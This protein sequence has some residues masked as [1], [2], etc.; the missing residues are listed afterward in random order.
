MPTPTARLKAVT[1]RLPLPEE[2][3]R[4]RA[5]LRLTR[6]EGDD[7]IGGGDQAGDLL[8]SRGLAALWRC[9]TRRGSRSLSR[10]A[11]SGYTMDIIT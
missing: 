11:L 5:K 8:S 3:K 7:L 10:A 2:T 6:E 1:E 4:I 9:S